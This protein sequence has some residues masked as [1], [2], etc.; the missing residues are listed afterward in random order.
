[1]HRAS[2]ALVAVITG[3]ASASPVFFTNRD[4]FNAAAGGGLAFESFEGE[5]QFGSLVTYGHLS[6]AESGG[7]NAITHTALNSFFSGATTNG[8]NSI[9][10]DD[11]GASLCTI[12]FG[13]LGQI[14][15][16]GFDLATA[17]NSVVTIRSSAWSTTIV[18]NAFTPRFF[19]VIDTMKP[20]GSVIIDAS[21]GPEVGFDAISYIPTPSA[22]VGLG[23]GMS[24]LGRRRVR[25]ARNSQRA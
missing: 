12:T 24:V 25:G 11:N 20:F 18:L 5:P 23:M 9:W 4:L 6:F 10:Y 22:G 19:G 8:A 1:M 7:L 17:E 15:A 16:I 14:S 13:E 21:G 3:S 2:F